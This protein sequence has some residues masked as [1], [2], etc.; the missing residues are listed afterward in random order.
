MSGW[1]PYSAINDKKI[2]VF[3]DLKPLLST[4]RWTNSEVAQQMAVKFASHSYSYSKLATEINYR[5]AAVE[6]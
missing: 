5:G 2:N 3:R 6:V 4:K 1:P